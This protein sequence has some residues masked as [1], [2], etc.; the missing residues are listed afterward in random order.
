[1]MLEVS[2]RHAFANLSL[3]VDFTAPAGITVLFGKSGS[4]K[5]TIVNAVAGLLRLDQGRIALNGRA[6][7]DSTAR[8]NLPPHRRR[9]P[10]VFQEARLFPHLTVRQN[11]NY[12]RWF[13]RSTLPDFDHLIEIL[14][15]APLL[16]RRPA[17]L[18]GGEKQRVALGRALL[19]GPDILLMD[20]PLAALDDTR[21]AEILPYIER[22]RDTGPP[23]LYV[24]HSMAEVARLATTLV[25]AEAGRTIAHGPAH[26]LL[27]DPALA[28]HLGLREAGAILSATLAAQEPDGL[29]RLDTAAGP[30]WLPQVDASIGSALRIRIAAQDVILSRTRPV[31]LSALN[32]LPATVTDLKP[33]D[34]P[35]VLVQLR[36]GG[37]HLLVRLTRRSA[38]AL[39]LVPGTEVFAIA[40]SVAVARSDIFSVPM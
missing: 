21:K 20:E 29:T 11:L 24:T 10:Y 36:V 2:F 30:L 5:T 7:Y 35:G 1:M 32:I 40:K 15:I 6:V 9:A 31:G 28:P 33:G 25:V 34:G 4:G 3:Q 37:E 14:D 22:L 19:A 38:E 23:I 12:G 27:A 17:A 26:S 16:N 13:T 18:S 39:A 8:V